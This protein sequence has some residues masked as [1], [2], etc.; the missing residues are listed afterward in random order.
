M[1]EEEKLLFQYTNV[2][3]HLYQEFMLELSIM[4]DRPAGS[5]TLGASTTI[6]PYL[7]SPVLSAF[8]TKF[9][10]IKLNLISGYSDTIEQDGLSKDIG[11]G[12]RE[13]QKTHKNLK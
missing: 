12:I 9:H 11:L 4:K 1:T 5:F 3:F 8:Q 7:L 2:I 10:E 6:A 13:G